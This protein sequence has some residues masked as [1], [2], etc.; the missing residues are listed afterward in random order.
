MSHWNSKSVEHPAFTPSHWTGVPLKVLGDSPT[1]ILPIRV[2]CADQSS[3]AVNVIG[4]A[5]VGVGVGVGVAVGV[6]VGKGVCVEVGVAL[7][8]AV[9]VGRGVGVA[10][11]TGVGVGAVVA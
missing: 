10:V 1:A 7:G 5:S 6:G 8:M 2:S 3:S 11:G 9:G 4:G